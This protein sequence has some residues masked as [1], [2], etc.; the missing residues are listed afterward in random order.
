MKWER[1]QH[2]Q[3]PRGRNGVPG[4]AGLGEASKEVGLSLGP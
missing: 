4:W 1:E 3:K 2:G